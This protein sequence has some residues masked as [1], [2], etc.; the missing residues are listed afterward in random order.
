MF[1]SPQ[2]FH[3]EKAHGNDPLEGKLPTNKFG[4]LASSDINHRLLKSNCGVASSYI[5]GG[6]G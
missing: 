4:N 3:A 1:S 6:L 2:L 5:L